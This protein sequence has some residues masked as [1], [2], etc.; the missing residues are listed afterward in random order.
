MTPLAHAQAL[1]SYARR[2]S[3]HG[4]AC[5]QRVRAALPQRLLL[6]V[7]ALST[8]GGIASIA[9]S[10]SALSA[11]IDEP[12]H[13]ATGME[14][15]QYGTYTMW[16]ENPPLARV[17]VALVPYLAGA[18]LP[19]ADA[20]NPRTSSPYVSWII[21]SQLI[22][23][24]GADARNL[25]QARC[26]TVLFFM[27]SVVL[28]GLIA[29]R[30]A[31][32]RAGI[33]AAC[34]LATQP[35]VLAH[36]GLATTDVAFMAMFLL[37]IW[38]LDRW[39]ARPD[40]GRALV[41]GVGL[42]L[43]VLTKF[44]TLLFFPAVV[45]IWLLTGWPLDR[46]SLARTVLVVVGAAAFVIWTGYGFSF[47]RVDDPR[48]RTEAGPYSILHAVAER[49]IIERLLTAS[50]L[51]APALFHG[52]LHLHAHSMAGDEA[53]L[54]GKVR[55]L[56]FPNFY[57]VTL[58]LKTPIPFLLLAALGLFAIL[59]SRRK[60]ELLADLAPALAGIVVV[61]IL[62]TSRVNLGV[63][64]ALIV[65]AL[66]AMSSGV[67]I[68]RGL[69]AVEGRRRLLVAIAVG[70]LLAWQQGIALAARPYFLSYFNAVAGFDPGKI[71]LDSDLDWGQGSFALA[72]EARERHI[73]TLKV[74]LWTG[75][76]GQCSGDMPTLEALVPHTPTTGWIA[77]SEQFYQ[78]FRE[79]YVLLNPC[80]PFSIIS[81]SGKNL[82][83]DGFRWL[84]AYE[85]MARPGGSIRLYYIP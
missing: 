41:C 61:G 72:R 73:R 19:A 4:H 66:F 11:T 13:V 68:A 42:G 17:A 81:L 9:S 48:F 14:F 40:P 16:T 34:L 57:P 25:V 75:T 69:D 28:A 50:P 82:P 76:V 45:V 20:W 39:L 65:Y 26:V 23:R 63:R 84:H 5:G 30:R 33:I 78:G 71:L 43:A 8:A 6:V 79:R 59:W 58:F 46:R 80:E 55:Q 29:M 44:T 15:L 18:R 31:G 32:W 52:L 53:Y 74:A 36:G 35:P 49:G 77:I 21:G 3:R 62:V 1:L 54:G 83:P 12:S 60:R 22:Q 67:G 70:I 85:P 38:G 27:A 47:G 51:P 24:D 37:A 56:G 64:H 7:I 10:W 2:A